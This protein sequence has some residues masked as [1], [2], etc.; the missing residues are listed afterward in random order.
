V[1]LAV[2][3][4]S[5]AF[6]QHRNTRAPAVHARTGHTPSASP[7][8]PTAE[9]RTNPLLPPQIVLSELFP[10]LTLLQ[11]SPAMPPAGFEPL[12][13][14]QDWEAYRA[15]FGAEADGVNRLKSSGI[16]A[17]S[18]KLIAAAIGPEP[19]AGMESAGLKRLLLIRA[20]AL[21]YR[22]R[23]G[24][25]TADKAVAAYQAMMDRHSIAQVAALWTISNAM[26]RM[27]VTP[28]PERIRYDGIAAKANMQLALNLLQAD[29]VE[30]AQAAIKAIGYH[31]GWLKSAPAIRSQIAQV[32]SRV[33]QSAKMMDYLATLYQPALHNDENALMV[34]Y[35]YGRYVKNNIA[36]VG[37]LPDRVPSSPLAHLA[38]SV[39]AAEHD[40][41]A[42]FAAAENLRVV[43]STLADSASLIK[44]R[45]LYAAMQNYRAFLNAPQTERDR[46][47]RTLAR[48][49]L[50]S[51]IADGAHGPTSIDPFAP[52]P[53]PASSP[54]TQPAP[55][56]ALRASIADER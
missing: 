21:C 47:H 29:Q 6:G 49:S 56:N 34:I 18:E 33:N 23:D 22:N 42:A 35:L 13:T 37:D 39:N 15:K 25:P 14:A 53:A 12:Y 46:I 2:A 45:T 19:T 3:L 9:A 5:V 16:L 20:A 28:K 24:Y 17:F 44:Q 51:V 7:A 43:A 10:D 54:A 31:E 4:A 11:K 8:S 41:M 55:G 40:P 27:A 52:P 26:S 1:A 50:E 32:R 30:A 36:I 48:M 38:A